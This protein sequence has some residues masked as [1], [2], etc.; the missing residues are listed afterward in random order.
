[1]NNVLSLIVEE[2]VK[3]KLSV[4]EMKS[5]MA[6]I[7]QNSSLVDRLRCDSAFDNMLIEPDFDRGQNLFERF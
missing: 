7:A 4:Q 3:E 1:M 2:L 6:E 5:L